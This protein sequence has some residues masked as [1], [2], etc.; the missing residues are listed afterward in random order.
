MESAATK[1]RG[2]SPP[3]S[4][5]GNSGDAVPSD[6]FGGATRAGRKAWEKP[7]LA[8]RQSERTAM[9]GQNGTVHCYVFDGFGRQVSYAAV[10][11]G[12]NVETA[13]SGGSSGVLMPTDFWSG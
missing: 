11:L 6:E 8:D 2:S 13:R 3:R 12:E 4:I 10:V 5:A 9:K 1:S 7:L